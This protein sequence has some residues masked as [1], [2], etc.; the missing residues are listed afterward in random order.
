M[1]NANVLF[2]IFLNLSP[3]WLSLHSLQSWAATQF[4]KHTALDIP[5]VWNTN[6]R[7][8]LI[9][10]DLY[11]WKDFNSSKNFNLSVSGMKNLMYV[12]VLACIYSWKK[13]EFIYLANLESKFYQMYVQKDRF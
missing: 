7:D 1:A 11:S 2:P 4:R 8:F 10:G 5:F 3:T 6:G 12:V 9:H 13:W